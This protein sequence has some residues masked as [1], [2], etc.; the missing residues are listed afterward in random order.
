V[1]ECLPSKY[2]SPEFNHSTTKKKK[3]E[4]EERRKTKA[5]QDGLEAVTT[6][7]WII[8]DDVKSGFEN[9]TKAGHS[10]SHL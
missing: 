9:T 2:E 3:I 1:V 4:E 7:C 10:S 6:C 5:A 8:Q